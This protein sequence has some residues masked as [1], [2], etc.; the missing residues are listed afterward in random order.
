M[1]F[2]AL[3]LASE[4][5]DDDMFARAKAAEAKIC[6][7]ELLLASGSLHFPLA[8][9]VCAASSGARRTAASRAQWRAKTR[10]GMA[11]GGDDRRAEKWGGLLVDSEEE[12]GLRDTEYGKKK[13][14]R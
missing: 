3:S 11:W 5:D 8:M 13:L 10:T 1:I 9:Q 4:D 7:R 12:E 2:C 6:A 14:D